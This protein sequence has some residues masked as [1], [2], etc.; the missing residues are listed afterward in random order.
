[1]SNS[2]FRRW[3]SEICRWEGRGF[4]L[5]EGNVGLRANGKTVNLKKNL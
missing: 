3:E 4:M 2:L 1:M 5:R